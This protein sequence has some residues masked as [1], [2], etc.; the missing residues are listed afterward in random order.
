MKILNEMKLTFTARSANEGFARTAAAAFIAS[1]DPRIDELTEV[2]TVV[3]E[4]VTNAI[5]H[6]YREYT[7]VVEMTVRILSE[8][9]VYIRIKDYGCG[10]F[11]VKRAMEPLFT[12]APDEER[13]GLGFA[14]MKTYTDKLTVKSRVGKGTVVTMYK[15]F[16]PKTK[17]T[18]E[19]SDGAEE[20]AE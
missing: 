12:T 8:N 18:E 6:G 20:A 10:I 3:S 7:G 14:V 19:L 2:K 4:A 11:D 16:S 15:T 17:H 9:R 1:I 13:S 5:V